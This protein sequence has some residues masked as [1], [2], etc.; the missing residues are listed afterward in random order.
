MQLTQ[1]NILNE[2]GIF[3]LLACITVIIENTMKAFSDDISPHL[4]KR[5]LQRLSVF[6][7]G[8]TRKSRAYDKQ[9]M[10]HVRKLVVHSEKMAK[11]LDNIENHLNI[12]GG[13]AQKPID[14]RQAL[15]LFSSG[16]VD[17]SKS[18]RI[19][20]ALRPLGGSTRRTTSSKQ[21]IS[22][23]VNPTDVVNKKPLATMALR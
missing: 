21:P 22:T 19:I 6:F 13:N 3:A 10:S 2:A 12:S 17:T 18:K 23:Q 14:K 9:L 1:K 15:R 11:R 5:G 8:T 20:D 7:T 4:E 16:D